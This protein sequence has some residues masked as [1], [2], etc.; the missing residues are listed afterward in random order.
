MII[1]AI[2]GTAGSGKGTIS[3]LLARK[4]GFCHLDTGAVYRSLTYFF[5]EQGID[6]EDEKLICDTLEKLD[7]K[8]K[9]EKNEFG[10]Q[11][12]KNLLF[13]KDLGNKIRTEKISISTSKISKFSCVRKF[14]NKIQHNI[15][16][17]YNLIVEGRDVGTV[18]FPNA[19][20]KF[21]LTASPEIRA[22]RRSEQLSQ[23]QN[24]ETIL[25]DII[26]RDEA[27][28]KRKTSPLKKADDAILI[29][30]SYQTVDET[31]SEI[32]SY[33]K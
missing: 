15:A 2:D 19:D 21:F 11:V 31:L 3:E 25:K 27:D 13:G 33:I 7:F 5:I 17:N 26:E 28:M 9:F 32:I 8:V 14:A 18:V 4:L 16:L 1:I 29:D 6:L 22:K 20:Y 23:P 24:Y 30:N 10:N 12:Q